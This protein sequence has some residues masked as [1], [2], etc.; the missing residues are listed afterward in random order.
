MKLFR[1]RTASGFAMTMNSCGYNGMV[2]GREA[3]T[4]QWS[5]VENEYQRRASLVDNLVEK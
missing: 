1:F 5:N 4:A 3:V 2:S